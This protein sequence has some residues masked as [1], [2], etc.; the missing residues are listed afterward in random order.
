[1]LTGQ[2]VLVHQT[3][4]VS[5]GISFFQS[6][7]NDGSQA[8][9]RWSHAA[10]MVTET[11]CVGA[12]PGGARLRPVSFFADKHISSIP[13]TSRSQAG[14]VAKYARDRIGTAYAYEDIPLIAVALALHEH[15]PNWLADQL[16]DDDRY[17]CSELAD[18]AV[19]SAGLKLLRD[20]RP[21]SAVYPAA[22]AQAL[23]LDGWW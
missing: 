13:Y 11:H 22:I 16:S 12:E 7:A 20:G 19:T 14:H 15:T 2:V 10:V 18:A 21:H 17:I 3:G 4:F 9:K 23:K 8:D 5:A 1:M 6:L